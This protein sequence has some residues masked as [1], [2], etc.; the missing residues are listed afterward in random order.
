MFQ[1]GKFRIDPQRRTLTRDDSAVALNRRSFDVLLY[2]VQNPGRVVTK[3]ELLKNVWPDANVDE[4]NL[5]Q[6]VSALRKALEERPGASSFITTEMCIRDRRE[7]EVVESPAVI[8]SIQM[9]MAAAP[10]RQVGAIART[11]DTKFHPADR[12]RK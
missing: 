2:L 12:C 8:G 1:F 7:V 4:N 3:E 11:A 5:T 10:G 6:S 9:G